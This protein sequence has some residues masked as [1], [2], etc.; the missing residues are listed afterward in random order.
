[1]IEDLIKIIKIRSKGLAE[2]NETS[3][4]IK[5]NGPHNREPVYLKIYPYIMGF[6]DF[7]NT[8]VKQFL[9]G[10]IIRPSSPLTIANSDRSLV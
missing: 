2:P 6:A 1:M 9:A 4:L 10:L 8:E 3:L 5:K 7:V